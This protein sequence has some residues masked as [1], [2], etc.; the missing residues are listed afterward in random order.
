MFS[1]LRENPSFTPCFVPYVGA[2]R[3]ERF[4]CQSPKAQPAPLQALP[5]ALGPKYDISLSFCQQHPRASSPCTAETSEGCSVHRRKL[6]AN[7]FMMSGGGGVD[8]GPKGMQE[9]VRRKAGLC[10][11]PASY[12]PGS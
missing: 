5:G 3:N 6:P 9:V 11:G 10:G 8:C 4:S 2:E 7:L 12:L 1:T